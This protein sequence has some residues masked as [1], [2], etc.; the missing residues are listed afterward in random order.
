[1]WDVRDMVH[2]WVGLV[3]DMHYP[4]P[5]Y[6]RSE[7]MVSSLLVV[8][9][10]AEVCTTVRAGAH[11]IFHLIIGKHTRLI[12]TN[13]T[14]GQHN[15][16]FGHDPCYADCCAITKIN[17]DFPKYSW[18]ISFVNLLCS[19]QCTSLIASLP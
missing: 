10:F 13:A 9:I 18:E 4:L 12:E 16:S 5:I 2:K 14:K 3:R 8:K 11:W 6:L 17:W 15:Y 1:M 7:S 19:L